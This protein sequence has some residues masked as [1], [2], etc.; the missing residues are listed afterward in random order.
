MN[1]YNRKASM[2]LSINMI[3]I[4]IMAVVVLGLGLGFVNGMFDKFDQSL[5][6]DEPTAPNP[7]TSEPV[8]VSRQSITVDAGKEVALKW[9]IYCADPTNCTTINVSLDGDCIGGTSTSR[10]N[11]DFSSV[12][13]ISSLFTAPTTIG[14]SLC[15]ATIIAG[16]KTLYK[17]LTLEV[18]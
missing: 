4:L 10:A 6:I 17:D 7:T 18:E 9:K 8:T 15:T 13:E 14:K 12:T 11:V 1:K 5:I 2:Q 3:V 16:S